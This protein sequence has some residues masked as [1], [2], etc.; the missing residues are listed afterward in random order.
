MENKQII[1]R[2]KAEFSNPKL[3]MLV[4]EMEEAVMNFV[5]AESNAK[6]LFS[7]NAGKIEAEK[8]YEAD[9]YKD[10]T[11]F[12]VKGLG[13]PYSSARAYIRTGHMIH[14]GTLPLND[15]NG[16]PF[17]FTQLRALSQI[18]DSKPRLEA[19]ARGEL[20]CST[21]GDAIEER[22]KE[23]NPE[24]KKPNRKVKRFMWTEVGSEEQLEN[25]MSK[26]ELLAYIPEIVGGAVMGEMKYKDELYIVFIHADGFPAM[27][28]QADEVANVVDAK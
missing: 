11:E 19:I 3:N 5:Q 22:A 23:I 28:R 14:E 7:I 10:V 9:G 2:E 1:V 6:V 26:E 4:K 20:N 15:A 25:P 17:N 27:F 12:Y 24:R 18:K 16:N 13:M 21:S 8:L